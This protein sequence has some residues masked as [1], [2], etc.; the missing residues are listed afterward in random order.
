MVECLQYRGIYVVQ[1]IRAQREELISRALDLFEG[2]HQI[3]QLNI[4]I[5]SAREQFRHTIA[6]SLAEDS[7][8]ERM[9]FQELGA[10][11]R[12]LAIGCVVEH[13]SQSIELIDCIEQLVRFE[14]TG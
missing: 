13:V 3:P 9:E 11:C 8:R 1:T 2:N 14:I 5:F 10:D 12:R 4:E 7:Q 6:M